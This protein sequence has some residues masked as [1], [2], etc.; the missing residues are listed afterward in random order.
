MQKSKVIKD[1]HDIKNIVIFF[2]FILTYYYNNSISTYTINEGSYMELKE[3]LTR[4]TNEELRKLWG[5]IMIMDCLSGW[6]DF[7]ESVSEAFVSEVRKRLNNGTMEHKFSDFPT[8]WE[9]FVSDCL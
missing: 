9:I 2:I 6:D 5:N 4:A 8:D 3:I 1:Y 7:A